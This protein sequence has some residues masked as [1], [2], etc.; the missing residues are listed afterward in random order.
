MRRN[1][2]APDDNRSPNCL[3]M[4]SAAREWQGS[5]APPQLV[6]VSAAGGSWRPTAKSN[7]LCIFL[8]MNRLAPIQGKLQAAETLETVSSA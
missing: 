4:V 8:K 2:V 1:S 3:V 5:A 7:H 6:M